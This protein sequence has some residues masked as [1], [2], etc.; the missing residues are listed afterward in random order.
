MNNNMI[1]V[2]KKY[3]EGILLR[4]LA[5]L[6]IYGRKFKKRCQKAWQLGKLYIA[7]VIKDAS[8][9]TACLL[10]FLR[11][12][13]VMYV[14]GLSLTGLAV[15]CLLSVCF[16]SLSRASLESGNMKIYP[17][18]SI[19]S[20]GAVSSGGAFTLSGGSVG[21]LTDSTQSMSGNNFVMNAGPIL[22]SVVL[23]I[24]KQN[25][26]TA[27]CYPV[28]FKPAMGHTRIRFTN[29]TQTARIMIYALSGI[30]IKTIYKSDGNDFID[31]DVKNN[32]GEAVF[33]GVYFYVVRN[34]LETKTGKLMIIR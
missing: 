8:T 34:S 27:H 23:D 9:H 2:R 28:P 10:I 7:V 20:G 29:L 30:I 25:L 15:F 32:K 6:E 24:S 16:I 1:R 4:F 14:R 12:L 21:G 11:K 31:W 33:S 3:F 19:T 26:S 17:A 18:L 22:A 13:N 5:P